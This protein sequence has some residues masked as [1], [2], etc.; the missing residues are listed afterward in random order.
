MISSLRGI[1]ERVSGG[2]VVIDVGGVGYGVAVTPQLA[3]ALEVG[4]SA[5]LMVTTIVREDAITLYGFE[6]SEA[7]HV[8]ETLLSVTGVGP[9]SALAVLAYLTPAQVFSAVASDDDTAFT[10][11]SGI[12]PKTAKLICVQLAGRLDSVATADPTAPGRP[13]DTTDAVV[14]ALIGLG[15]NERLARE[16]VRPMESSGKTTSQLLREALAM[17]AKQ[18]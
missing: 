14:S 13:T 3:A 12:G 15:W 5:H 7:S 17:M 4:A 10:K 11:V 6:S 9:R 18:S 16:T 8:F 2:L 1:V